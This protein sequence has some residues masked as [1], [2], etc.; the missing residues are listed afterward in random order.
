[1]VIHRVLFNNMTWRYNII[2]EGKKYYIGEVFLDE[3]GKLKNLYWSKFDDFV[4]DSKEDLLNCLLQFTAD[5]LRYNF[6]EVKKN[7]LF[8]TKDNVAKILCKLK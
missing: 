1:V 8:I 2:K 3:K 7:K 6:L 5:S 4:F